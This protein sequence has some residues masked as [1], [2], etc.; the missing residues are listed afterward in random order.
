MLTIKIS[1]MASLKIIEMKIKTTGMFLKGF[2]NEIKVYMGNK[3]KR[4]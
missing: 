4:S 2:Y 1:R 3:E